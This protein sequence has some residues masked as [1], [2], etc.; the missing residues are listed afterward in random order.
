MLRTVCTIRFFSNCVL[1]LRFVILW[2]PL[3][4]EAHAVDAGL[5]L[6]PCCFSL[7]NARH[8]WICGVDRPLPPSSDVRWLERCGSST[9]SVGGLWSFKLL[10]T[11]LQ[12]LLN[13]CL[14]IIDC[15]YDSVRH[16][17]QIPVMKPSAC[18]LDKGY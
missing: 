4:D 5:P 12:V 3:E 2:M 14:F 8:H 17:L 18:S 11:C 10:M 7:T 1:L 16:H 13:P 9:V 6:C 15:E